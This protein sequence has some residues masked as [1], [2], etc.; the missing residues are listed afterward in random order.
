ML[1][2]ART[3]EENLRILK[4]ELT[5]KQVV[6]KTSVLRDKERSYFVDEV[7]EVRIRTER[8]NL[9][10]ARLCNS[11]VKEEDQPFLRYPNV[12]IK[13][14]KIDKNK[15]KITLVYLTD[16]NIERDFRRLHRLTKQDLAITIIY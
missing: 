10:G 14:E 11:L 12:I 13:P 5:G 16:I 1:E 7:K 6:I 3:R 8:G 2:R 9:L 4:E 15:K